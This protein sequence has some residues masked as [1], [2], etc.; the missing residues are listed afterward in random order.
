MR[1]LALLLTFILFSNHIL[2]SQV[3]KFTEL[4]AASNEKTECQIYTE[5]LSC[6]QNI[7]VNDSM[8]LFLSNW[9]QKC[10]KSE[11]L[12]RLK[13]IY[14]IQNDLEADSLILEYFNNFETNMYDRIYDSR[15]KNYL[16]I[17]EN[18]TDYYNY[19]PLK[20]K[21]DSVIIYAAENL[22]KTKELS[23]DEQLICLLFSHQI[24]KYEKSIHSKHY[25]NALIAKKVKE[26]KEKYKDEDLNF[27]VVAGAWIPLSE[28]K[29]KMGV[30]PQI[31]V[32]IGAPY[33][34]FQFDLGV[35]FRINI[36]NKDFEIQTLTDTVFTDSDIGAF[37]GG[38]VGYEMFSN[39]K[40]KL[41]PKISIGADILDTD[42]LMEESEDED[43]EEYYTIATFNL[44]FGVNLLYA[45]WGNQYLGLGINYHY[46]P[47]LTDRDL[48]SNFTSDILTLNLVYRF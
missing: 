8:Q 1:N 12:L 35:I 2:Y 46:V 38:S 34:K 36:N 3:D 4:L 37:L 21:F 22:L 29:I 16:E 13:I 7:V 45:V 39:N 10:F 32:M 27:L 20:S 11:P 5:Y 18:N 17:F 25:K 26:E 42:V 40:W 44:G 33:K 48:I 31:G 43:T 9:E 24:D 6:K 47:Y 23:S 19:I 15:S 41:I 30:N 28:N 14:Q